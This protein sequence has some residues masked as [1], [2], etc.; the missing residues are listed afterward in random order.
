M[1]PPAMA[2]VQAGTYNNGPMIRFLG[3]LVLILPLLGLSACSVNPATGKE[4]F[5]A[6]MSRADEMEV[7]AKEHPKILK[8]HGGAYR[9]PR[10]TGYVRR[11]ALTLTRVSETPDFPYTI[12]T[13]NDE[14]VNAFALPGGYIYITRGLLALADNEAEMAGVLAHEIGHSV[15]RH[16]AERYS[17]AVAANLGLNILG[18]IGGAM[19]A[20]PGI[21]NIASFGTQAYLQSFSREQELE[22][23]LLGVRYLA[24]AGYDP[25]AMTSFLHK[26]QA[27]DRLEAALTGDP[28][29]EKSFNIM[30]TH[31]RTADRIAQAIGLA[32]IAPG[33]ALRVERDAYLERID[34]MVFGDDVAQG[35]RRGRE[36]AHPELRFRFEVPPGFVLFN[37]PDKVLA[38]GPGKSVIAFDMAEK[39]VN[40]LTAYLVRDWGRSYTLRDVEIIDVN[41]ME[42]ATGHGRAETRKG[43]RDL[44]LVVLRGGGKRIFRFAFLTPPGL[45][46][47]L[48]TD[49]RR[50]TY[51]FRRITAHE[52]QAI[53][54]L[55]LAV[56][57][58]RPGD[59]AAGLAARLPFENFRLERFETLNGLES[60]QPLTPGSRVKTVRD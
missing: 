44:R 1:I 49:L 32:R 35:V 39:A 8:Q 12:T 25:A 17:K 45:T 3:A 9:Y 7:G 30:S 58:V 59:T 23:D 33:G 5:T 41:G 40:S 36:F 54:P 18:A 26:L 6:F 21:G 28:G 29:K 38:R 50:T 10:L 11:V 19:G 37:N 56:I 43:A 20:P 60:D 42:A 46:H 55:R 4:S 47:R 48:A 13:L 53:R 27:N 51:S 31:P 22:A 2:P 16:T 15:A 34:G 57:P 52:A 14:S 24:R